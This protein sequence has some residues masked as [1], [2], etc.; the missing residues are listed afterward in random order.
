MLLCKLRNY[1]ATSE[2]ENKASGWTDGSVDKWAS[3][4]LDNLSF[5][6]KTLWRKGSI[7]VHTQFCGFHMNSMHMCPPTHTQGNNK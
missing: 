6:P 2:Q 3:N 4:L 5:I 7:N 1:T